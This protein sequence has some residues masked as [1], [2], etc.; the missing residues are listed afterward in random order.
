MTEGFESFQLAVV[1]PMNTRMY[2]VSYE[3]QVY[4]Q[5]RENHM[6]RVEYVP[7]AYSVRAVTLLPCLKCHL[8]S[9]VVSDVLTQSPPTIDEMAY[10]LRTPD[11]EFVVLINKALRFDIECL[12]GRFRP[13]L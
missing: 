6:W 10:T 2:R 3:V 13:P 7:L 8:E 1:V 5:R 9:S 12:N 11:R 4:P